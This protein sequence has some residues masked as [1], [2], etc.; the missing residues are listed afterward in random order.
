MLY[1]GKNAHRL[2]CLL[3]AGLMAILSGPA[4][5]NEIQVGYNLAAGA[6]S[7]A[8][9]IPA[10]NT[11]VSV[12]CVQSNVGFRGIGQATML[13]TSV[14]PQFLEWVGMDVATSAVTSG[15]GSTKGQHVIYCDYT[16]K[17][18]DMQVSAANSIQIVNTGSTAAAGIINFVW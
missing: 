14:A 4:F 9:V 18:V 17:T 7:G 13:K 16:G 15:F 8:I 1:L 5:A 3:A 6:T 12:T 11:P 10:F 2:K